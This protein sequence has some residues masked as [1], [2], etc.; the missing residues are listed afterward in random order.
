MHRL[1]ERLIHAAHHASFLA[2]AGYLWLLDSPLA[3]AAKKKPQVVPEAGK[4]YTF[5]YIIV[6]A[7]VAVGLMTVLR[8]SKRLDKALNMHTKEE[9]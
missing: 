6:M 7:V 2:L 1:A 8:P 5:P 9:K 3:W 4:S